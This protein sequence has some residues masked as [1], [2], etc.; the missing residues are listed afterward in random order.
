MCYEFT[1][2]M[3]IIFPVQAMMMQL[4]PKECLVI[5]HDSNTDAKKLIQVLQRS[6]VMV[7]ERKRGIPFVVV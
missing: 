5:S 4:R 3:Y 6:N 7:T 1:L 2:V